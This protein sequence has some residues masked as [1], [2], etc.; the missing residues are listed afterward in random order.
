MHLA[1]SLFSTYTG[2]LSST[3]FV[4]KSST[5]LLPPL[6]SEKVLDQLRERIRYLHYS[7]RTEEVYVYRVCV[8]HTKLDTDSRRNWTVIPRQ[9]GHRFQSKLDSHL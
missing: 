3:K 7:I 9:T 1:T 6:K 4:M 5:V 8:F 2:F